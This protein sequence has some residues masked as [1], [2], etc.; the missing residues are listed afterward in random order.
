[1]MEWRRLAVQVW[2][3]RS[4]VLEAVGFAALWVVLTLEA[5]SV[6]FF[7][8]W[9]IPRRQ[10]A[11]S[12]VEGVIYTAVAAAILIAGWRLLGPTIQARFTCINGDLTASGVGAAGAA[13]GTGC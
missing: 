8:R 2:K 5:L 13:A 9:A 4:A 12:V 3:Y 7:G 1:M 6:W 10:R 11:Q